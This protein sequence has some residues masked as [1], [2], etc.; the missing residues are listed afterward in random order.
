MLFSAHVVADTT[1]WG[2]ATYSASKFGTGH[3]MC[4]RHTATFPIACV[5]T[6]TTALGCGTYSASEFGTGHAVSC[7]CTT[8]FGDCNARRED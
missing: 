1:A 7:R 5:V 4:T 8:A 6:N 2:R 3:V